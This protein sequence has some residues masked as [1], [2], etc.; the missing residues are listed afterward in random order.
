[1]DLAKE[2]FDS[3]NYL[4]NSGIFVLNASVWLKAISTFRSDIANACNQSF[5]HHTVDQIT[6]DTTFIRPAMKSFLQIPA[7][8][9]DYAV[10]EKCPTSNIPISVVPIDAG[11]SDLGAW[12]AVWKVGNLD[13][14]GNVVNGD[15]ILWDTKN[16]LVH[17]TGRLVSLLG[18]DDLVV[19][20]TADAVL[21][22]NR[23][24]CQNVKMIVHQLDQEGRQ[25]KSI[26]R[27]VS[28]PW[29]WYDSIE[30]GDHFKVKRL[31]V[32]PGESLSLQ[33]HH[34]R[35]EHW[36]VIKGVAE[37][38]NGD[39]VITLCENQ[40]TYIPQGQTHRLRNPGE[41]PLEIIEVQSG[42]YVGEDDIVRFDDLYGRK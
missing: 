19:I 38:T 40:S 1:M 3:G 7:E 34:H 42:S 37:V 36:I 10:M 28:R 12:D 18:V 16:S 13:R 27:K 25:E 5:E 9:V 26:H 24:H 15:A 8:S 4:W 33:M 35:S 17:A 21:V 22:A 11:W 39:Q 23:H 32:K 14:H 31:L 6:R 2:Y 29:G 41:G 30:E 20:E